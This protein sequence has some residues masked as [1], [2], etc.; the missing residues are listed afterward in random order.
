M[1]DKSSTQSKQ[2]FTVEEYLRLE[3][4]DGTKHEFYNGKILAKSGSG[5]RHNLICSNMTIAIGSRVIGQK[6]EVYVNDMRVRLN[7]GNFCYPDLV[8]VGADPQFDD[9]ELDVLLNPTLIVEVLSQTTSMRDKTEKLEGYLAMDSVK[10]CLLVRE[11]DMKVEHYAKQGPKQWIYKIYDGRDDIITLG[12]INCKIS[13]AE[14]YS[15]INFA[16]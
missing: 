6:S 10:E 9:A 3:K 2:R 4:K 8:V 7:S 11:E 1:N 14:I 16:Q 13:V 15:Q 5:R 12:A